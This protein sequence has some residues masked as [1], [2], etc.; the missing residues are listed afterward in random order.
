MKKGFSNLDWE[1]QTKPV[2]VGNTEACEYQAIVRDDNN[3]ILQIVPKTYIPFQNSIL[4]DFVAQICDTSDFKLLSYGEH[5]GGR[6]VLAYLESPENRKIGGFAFKDYLVI[7]NGHDR[8]TPFFLATTNVMVRCSNQFSK[9]FAT[10][11][12]DKLF[13][14]HHTKNGLAKINNLKK[15]FENYFIEQQNLYDIYES[16]SKVKID[17]YLIEAVIT[18]LAEAENEEKISTR[19]QNIINAMRGSAFREISEVGMN[20]FGLFNGITHYTT[21]VMKNE[22]FGTLFGTAYKINEKALK[23]CQ[24]I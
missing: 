8:A 24:T 3:A 18:R 7:G 21:H 10:K 5:K 1:V 15:V 9:I 17:T 13:N 2:F 23:I 19:K 11:T 22:N 14:V 12:T 4:K 6:K 20:A 16:L